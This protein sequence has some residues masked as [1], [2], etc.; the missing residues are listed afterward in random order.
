MSPDPNH[1]L[2]LI[3]ELEEPGPVSIF[4]LFK[5]IMS[6]ITLI[7]PK[8]FPLLLQKQA[9]IPENFVYKTTNRTSGLSTHLMI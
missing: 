9:D 1:K 8:D 4:N 7:D 6:I 3:T 2:Y 5:L